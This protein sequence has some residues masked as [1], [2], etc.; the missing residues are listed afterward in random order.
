MGLAYY[1]DRSC[2]SRRN[3]T[4]SSSLSDF[5]EIGQ[6]GAV[7]L[8]NETRRILKRRGRLPCTTFVSWLGKRDQVVLLE[9]AARSLVIQAVLVFRRTARARSLSCKYSDY[10]L[11]I[12]RTGASLAARPRQ[13][14]IP[15]IGSGYD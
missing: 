4:K 3:F 12:Q 5:F 10:R 9:T 15:V 2:Q 14:T 1:S 6:S 8:M 11:D 7:W 13:S